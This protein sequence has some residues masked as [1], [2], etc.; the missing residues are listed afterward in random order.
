MISTSIANPIIQPDFLLHTD[1]AKRLYHDY[2]AE[3]PIIDYHCHLPPDQIASDH[4]FTNL[5]DIWLRGDHYKWRAMRANGVPEEG[6]TGS[7]TDREKHRNWAETLPYT[8]RNPLYHWSL[9]ELHR[10]FGIEELLGPDNAN[11]IYDRCTEQ[12]QQPEFRV[13]ALLERMNVRT[14]C[15]TDDP[16]DELAHHRALADSDFGI[17]VFPTFRPDK[18]VMISGE[19]YNDYVD[20]LGGAAG[21]AIATYEDLL[22]ALELRIDY[23]HQLGCRV[24][25]HGLNQLFDES[26]NL[27]EV[28]K[29]FTERRAGRAVSPEAARRFECAIMIELGR[30]YHARDW[31]MQL[32]LGALRNNNDRILAQ[33]GADA[34][35]DSIGDFSQAMGLRRL[36]NELDRDDRLPRTIVY[37]LNP[38][39]NEVMATM[40][41]N[42]NDGSVAGKMQF[43]SG[44]WFLDQLDGMEKQI[45][46]LSNMGLLSRFVG[47]LTDSRSFLSYPR[48][49]YFR[50][51][52]CNMFGRDIERGL[53]PNDEGW[54]GQ[55]IQDICYNN[56]NQYFKF[57]Q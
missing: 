29:T 56:A 5:T 18:A 22:S 47:M 45:D 46:T 50:R 11:E 13:R 48:H 4:Q 2:A 54:I 7:G 14:V 9:L 17:K 25:D 42:Y 39:D 21:M 8:M 36:L 40:V 52:L 37:N 33:L 6:I 24:S 57:P 20:R 38:A 32:H 31:A 23:F 34:G 55:M 44:W 16:T 30:M 35:V 26:V 19:H 28:Q 15:T 51:L 3:M 53:L 12:L 10:Y 1:Y 41:G 43:G 49:E 27:G